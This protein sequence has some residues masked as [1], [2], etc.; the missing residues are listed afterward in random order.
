MRRH[1]RVLV[2]LCYSSALSHYQM[3]LEDDDEDAAAARPFAVVMS[4]T[5]LGVI[6]ARYTTHGHCD[7]H[8]KHMITRSQ[9]CIL[10]MH[11]L[12]DHERARRRFSRTGNAPRVLRWDGER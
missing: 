6:W 12:D 2:A 9:I 8:I 10:P 4:W 3:Q 1:L 11:L 7:S 5:Y